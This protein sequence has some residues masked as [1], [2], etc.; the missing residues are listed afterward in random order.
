MSGVI[1]K[2][3]EGDTS[4]S[5]HSISASTIE[6]STGEKGTRPVKG[7]K[8]I[9]AGIGYVGGEKESG[10]EAEVSYRHMLGNTLGLAGGALIGYGFGSNYY[11][12]IDP[13]TQD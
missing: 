1:R 13:S 10:F 5:E 2:L 3:I 12:S 6:E 11:N 9:E 8:F 7:N 4:D